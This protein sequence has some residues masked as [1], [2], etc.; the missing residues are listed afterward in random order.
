[1]EI[2]LHADASS[3]GLGAVLAQRQQ[4][5]LRPI[6]FASRLLSPAERNYTI[7]EKECPAIVWALKKFLHFVWG[8]QIL[9]ITDHHTFCWLLTKKDLTGR[10]A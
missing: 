2:E 7:T 6:A 3:Y 4:G 1:M 8:A 10:L 9:V 5:A